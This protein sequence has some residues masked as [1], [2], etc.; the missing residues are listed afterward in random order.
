ML[1]DVVYVYEFVVVVDVAGIVEGIFHIDLGAE[2][3]CNVIFKHALCERVA[4][5]QPFA[6]SPHVV[7]DSSRDAPFRGV[8][9][10]I[11]FPL[12]AWQ[13]SL[14]AALEAYGVDVAVLSDG[15][16][17][18]CYLARGGDTSVAELIFPAGVYPLGVEG[19]A[20]VFAYLVL[21]QDRWIDSSERAG[22]YPGFEMGGFAFGKFR[23]ACRQV[24]RPGRAELARRLE[25]VASLSVV[26]RYLLDIL[27]RKFAEVYLSVLGIAELYAVVIYPHV[28]AAHAA[29]VYGLD[30][31][32]AA[33]IFQL[34]A[35]EV[36]QGIGY[37]E[38]VEA[39]EFLAGEFLRGYNLAVS[40]G[41]DDH[42]VELLYRVE[43]ALSPCDCGRQE[44]QC[45]DWQYFGIDVH[46]KAV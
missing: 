4:V 22:L 8:V 9:V 21:E 14:Q 13:I 20:E 33:V 3:L 44:E 11:G 42:F 25:D 7:D 34:H 1:V 31:A 38:A 5:P 29:Y 6:P 39:F 43:L 10:E 2:F 12:A 36:S 35:R 19:G 41:R 23:T 16:G 28:V 46:R 27:Q 30:T 15:C 24:N 37:R 17:V 32:H 18:V 26:E 45:K 40:V